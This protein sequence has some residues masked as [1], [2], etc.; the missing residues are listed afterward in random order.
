[1]HTHTRI[2]F[3]LLIIVIPIRAWIYELMSIP[4]LVPGVA[5]TTKGTAVSKWKILPIC[6]RRKGREA[7]M[8]WGSFS[9][10]FFVGTYSVCVIVVLS[11]YV[12]GRDQP[13]GRL[14]LRSHFPGSCFFFFKK[15]LDFMYFIYVY[16]C[17]YYVCILRMAGGQLVGV[18]SPTI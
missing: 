15:K 4:F 9:L 18:G 16:M 10:S 5:L 1:M 6:L 3:F 13:S 8:I 11:V 2:N 7:R 14:L 12:E 17:I